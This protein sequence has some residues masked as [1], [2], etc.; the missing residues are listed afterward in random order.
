M[1]FVTMEK[2]NV[3]S[4]RSSGTIK[5]IRVTMVTMHNTILSPIHENKDVK[6]ATISQM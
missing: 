2:H 3:K 6:K 5:A 4:S 1:A